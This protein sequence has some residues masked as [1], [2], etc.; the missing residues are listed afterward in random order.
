[1]KVSIGAKNDRVGKLFLAFTRVIGR[2]FGRFLPMNTGFSQS[3][4]FISGLTRAAHNPE[5]VGSEVK[6]D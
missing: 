4:F 6:N 1:M 5:V 2:L 3:W